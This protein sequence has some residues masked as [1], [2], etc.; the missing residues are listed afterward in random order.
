MAM[1]SLS[2]ALNW[3]PLQI[4]GQQQQPFLRT[5][6]TLVSTSRVSCSAAE[7]RNLPLCAARSASGDAEGTGNLVGGFLVPLL[8]AAL[9]GSAPLLEVVIK[10]PAAIADT[11]SAEE[12]KELLQRIK[13]KRG[14]QGFSAPAPSV[15]PAPAVAVQPEQTTT[16]S[17]ASVLKEAAEK[18]RQEREA[19]ALRAERQEAEKQAEAR[20]AREATTAAQIAERERAAVEKVNRQKDGVPSITIKKK[21]HGFLPLFVSQFFLLLATLGVG[22]VLFVLPEKQLK[23]IQDKIDEAVDKVTP[24]AEDIYVKGKPF[25]EKAWVKAQEAGVVAKPYVEKAW[26]QA[27]PMAAKAVDASK[28]LLKEAQ[29]KANELLQEAQKKAE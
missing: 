13:E 8:A 10:P 5:K 15:A 3:T 9:V 4:S 14:R 25:A 6:T 23:E 19:E 17:A 29:A 11:T 7:P 20:R 16:S 12:Y 22:A 26:E 28:P 27:K 18:A 2:M 21:T 24:I 1:A